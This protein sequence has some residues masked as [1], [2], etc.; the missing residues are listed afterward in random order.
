[1]PN[2]REKKNKNGETISFDIRVYK[3]R[4]NTGKQLKPYIMTW[5]PSP[6]MTAKQIEKELNKQATLFE[7]QCKTGYIQDNK[8]TFAQYAEY[9]LALKERVITSYSIHYTKLYDG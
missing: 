8:Q 2:I 9:V 6:N 4:D 7:E 1:M 5:K 3:G